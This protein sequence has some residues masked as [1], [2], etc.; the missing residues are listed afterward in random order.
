M[1]SDLMWR[2]VSEGEALPKTLKFAL[3][4]KL[5]GT[6]GT[7]GD[8]DVVVDSNLIPYLEG[9]RDA[10]IDGAD[11]LIKLIETHGAVVLWHQF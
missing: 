7:C 2:P 3:S 4:K 8:G 10:G 5:W 1:S 11:R 9:L 6:D